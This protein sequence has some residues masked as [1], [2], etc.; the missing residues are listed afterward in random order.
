MEKEYDLKLPAS[1]VSAALTGLSELPLKV[2]VDAFFR[3]RQQVDAQDRPPTPAPPVSEEAQGEQLLTEVP[4]AP[5]VGEA[6]L[7]D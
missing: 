1:A 3:I 7:K 4:P 5:G 2:S 6:L